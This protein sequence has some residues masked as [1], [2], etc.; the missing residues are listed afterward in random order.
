VGGAGLLEVPVAHAREAAE[1]RLVEQGLDLGVQGGL[2]LLEGQ[3]VIPAPPGDRPRDLALAADRVDRD[4]RP[5]DVQQGEQFRD[6]VDLVALVAYRDLPEDHVV[7]GDERADQVGHAAAV[8]GVL[9]AAADALAVDGDQSPAARD[10]GDPGDEAPLERIGVEGGEHAAERVV[11]RHAAGQV[12]ERPEPRQLAAGEHL[13]L[14]P[15]AGAADHAADGQD[16]DVV[17]LVDHVRGPRVGQA[18]E[19]A[20]HTPGRLDV[21]AQAPRA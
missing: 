7:V 16:D 6:G 3:H 17:Q 11:A 12:E 14:G 18:Q 21:H 5:R 20:Q 2:V 4:R 9:E 13:D 15:P 10:L 19:E 1:D 8:P